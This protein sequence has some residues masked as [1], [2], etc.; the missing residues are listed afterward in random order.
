[1]KANGLAI[2][3][4]L[5]SC[6]NLLRFISFFLSQSSTRDCFSATLPALK[7]FLR[8]Q[9]QLPVLLFWIFQ[10]CTHFIKLEL[11]T[12]FGGRYLF[13]PLVLNY[14]IVIGTFGA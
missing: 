13:D 7:S 2:G 3:L 9:L 10:I 12:H 14:F 4:S 5:I 6:A 11:V 1:M 8:L